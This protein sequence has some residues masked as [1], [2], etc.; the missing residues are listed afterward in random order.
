MNRRNSKKQDS[1]DRIVPGSLRTKTW[2]RFMRGPDP[3]LLENLYVPALGEAVRYDRCCAY[4][5]SS[6]LAAAARGFGKLIERLIAM[7]DEAP[8]PAIRLVVNEELSAD[9]VKALTESGDLSGLEK[10]LK[11]RFK[12][13][14]D[15]LTKQRLAMLGW[16]TKHRYLDIRVGVMRYGGGLVHAKF[17]ITTDE[18][19]DAVV[20]NGSGNESAQGL[21]ANYERLEVSTSW[22]DPS[23]YEEYSTEFE[24]LWNKADSTPK[25]N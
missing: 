8:K 18:S 12:N 24:A 11:R 25:C 1:K 4:F 10:A 19:N 22:E 16:L 6:V 17:G 23:R 13:P 14:K 15:L 21:L 20:F 2:V 9:D 7:G 5:S 3:Q